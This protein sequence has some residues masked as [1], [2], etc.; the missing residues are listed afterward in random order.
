MSLNR[1]LCVNARR[2]FFYF[3]LSI[4][5]P[6]AA[7]AQD[8]S[9]ASELLKTMNRPVTP[10]HIIGN[11]YYVGASDIGV[12]LIVSPA[13][14]IL[15]DGGFVET[16]PQIEANIQTLGFRLK[17]VKFILNSHA[18]LDHAGGISEM[19]HVTGAKFVAMDKD[20][21]ALTAGTSFPAAIPDRVIHDGDTVTVGAVTMTAHL[22]PGHTRG[23]TTWTMVARNGVKRY[24]VVFVGSATVLPNY[25]LIDL[26]N[27]PATYPGIQEDY[28]KTFRVLRSLPCDVFLASHGSFYSLTDKRSVASKNPAQNPFIDPWGYQAYILRAE[29]VFQKELQKEQSSAK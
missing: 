9:Q 29:G 15:L 3:V 10:F 28:E 8:P 18:H 26:P 21:P 27:V 6:L 7:E 22:T 4:V 23:C 25:K 12:Y 19:K 2:I 20:V 13:G 16:A 17:D 1:S 14:D 24:N 11:I 5:I